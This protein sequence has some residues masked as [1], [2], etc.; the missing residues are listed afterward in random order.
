MART[1]VGPLEYTRRT[2]MRLTL[3]ATFIFLYAPIVTLVAFSFNDSRRN[4]VWRGF[5]LKY[6]EKALGN[7]ELIEAFVNSLA[8]ALLST[9]IATVLG[10][11]TALLL[12]RFRF[13]FKAGYEGAMALPI[14][15]P[16][17]CMG[18]AMLAFFAKVGWPSGLPW[19]FSLSAIIIAHVSFSFPFV[20]VV[21]RARLAGFNQELAEAAQDLG[22]S[23]W[24]VFWDVMVPFMRPGLVAGALLA[25]TLSLDDFVITF[26]TSGPDT[27]TFP[28]KVYSM[29][30][31]SVT[32]EVNAASTVLIL[33]TVVLTG[34]A[35]WMQ[36]RQEKDK[37]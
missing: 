11:L 22:A 4:I 5:T 33:L 36:F 15:I 6:Y 28:V 26:F 13:P 24:R 1:P 8:I 37:S 18:V 16:E 17:I 7:S 30:R 35:L 34:I 9:V 21:V 10:A 25:F 14:V 20:A 3:L 2:W 23:E 31:F 29:V 27:V 32:P 19:P 12:W